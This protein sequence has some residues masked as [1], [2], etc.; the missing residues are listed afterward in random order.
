MFEQDL[1]SVSGIRSLDGPRNLEP[2]CNDESPR[3]WHESVVSRA[4]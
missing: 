3:E 4:R 1:A 2:K